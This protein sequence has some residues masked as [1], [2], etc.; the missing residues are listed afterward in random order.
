MLSL[1][2]CDVCG[3]DGFY[4]VLFGGILIVF[5]M[6]F[7]GVPVFWVKLLWLSFYVGV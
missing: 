3:I 2:V 4:G 6:V 5:W 7:Y 1:W